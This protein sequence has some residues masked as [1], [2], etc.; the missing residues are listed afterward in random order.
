MTK[1]WFNVCVCAC[2]YVGGTIGS[3]ACH[4]TGAAESPA[5]A[6]GAARDG[7]IHQSRQVPLQPNDQ[8]T[9]SAEQK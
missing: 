5:G 3:Y 8:Q 1:M 2:I 4:T 9:E 6:R 7:A